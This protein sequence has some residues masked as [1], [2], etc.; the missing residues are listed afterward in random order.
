MHLKTYKSLLGGL[1]MAL[2][3]AAAAS[4]QPAGP[5]MRP[6][7]SMGVVEIGEATALP[8]TPFFPIKGYRS[9][10]LDLYRPT[11][12]QGPFPLVLFVHGGAW[13]TGDSREGIF[14]GTDASKEFA[15]LAA[16]GYVVASLNYRLTGE[17]QFPAQIQ[18][19]RA[20]MQ[21]LRFHTRDLNSSGKMVVVGASAGGYLAA[22][23]GVS[24][25]DA[26][27]APPPI[28][29]P[30]GLRLPPMPPNT[31]CADGVVA[32]YPVVDIPTLAKEPVTAPFPDDGPSPE[33]RLLG[34]KP[35]ACSPQ[36]L[37]AASI[38]RRIDAKDPPMLIF[39][40]DA[41]TM[42]PIS[43]SRLL[44][45]ALKKAGVRSELVVVPGAKHIFPGLTPQARQEIIDRTA[46]FIDEQTRA[47]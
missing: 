14:S 4:A 24:C 47:R 29:P 7:I 21:W 5:P 23:A 30:P 40:G 39:H 13:M 19:V 20:A 9:L 18:D 31:E 34:C 15:A 41:D 42:V 43:Q 22:L 10:T 46:R 27:F 2:G 36:R 25:G 8:N 1:A 17:A 28:Q 37:A 6:A 32:F 38:L 35:S 26:S 44:D 12:A 11:K 45:A 16:R 3:L 33:A